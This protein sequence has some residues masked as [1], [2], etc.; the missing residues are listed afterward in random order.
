VQQNG[1]QDEQTRL[2]ARQTRAEIAAGRKQFVE[3]E[4]LLTEIVHSAP[5]NP[6]QLWEAHAGL[7]DLYGETGQRQKAGEHFDKAI[8][9]MERTRSEVFQAEHRATYLSRWIRFYQNYV[10]LLMEGGDSGK[11]FQV[12]ELSRARILAERMGGRPSQGNPAPLHAYQE[13]A[14][15][16]GT[17]LLSYWIAPRRSFL[18]VI[19]PRETRT[20]TLPGEKEIAALVDRHQQSLDNLR[21]PLISDESA[22][23]RLYSILLGQ[24]ASLVPAGFKV[25]LVP[26]GPLHNLNFET[27]PVAGKSRHYWVEDVTLS[28]APSLGIVLLR[29]AAQSKVPASLLLIGD[30]EPAGAD[31]PK[32]AYAS[33]EVAEIER[34]FPN[35][36]KTVLTGVR[37]NPSTYRESQPEQFS[38]IHF[39]AHGFANRASPLD[40]AVILSPKSGAF[41]LYAREIAEQPLH[42]QLVTI[43]S[44]R[45]AGAKSY[46]GEGLLGLAWAFLR[47][48]ANEVIAGLWDANDK[49]TAEIMAALYAGL[50]AGKPPADALH[51]AKLAM[52]R[53]NDRYHQPY[54]WG[55]FQDYTGAHSSR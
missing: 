25:I 29:P 8:S 42:A 50:A 4:R 36:T 54:Y 6:A 32:L 23:S 9:L 12:S 43:A 41:M 2:S 28:V 10:D 18:W 31:Y 5:S 26:D 47:A 46:P 38:L 53:R 51:E 52:V 37:A 15:R 27:L 33:R 20:F 39:A 13:A 40:S 7:G 35:V 16:M 19:T 11:A 44:C 22:G 17:L 55:A 24:A 21:D 34:A 3:A 1:D 45:S 14:R 49:S 48:G 30:P